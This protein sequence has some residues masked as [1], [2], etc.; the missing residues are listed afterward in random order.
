MRHNVVFF[1]SGPV[2]AMSLENLNK[3]Y[4]VELV[5]T[6]KRAPHHKDPA[7]VEVLA[8]NNNLS[9]KFAD[10]KSELE[11]IILT[12]QLDNACGIVIDYGVIISKKVIDYFN[13][14]IVN[15]HFSLLPQWRGADPISFSLLSGQNTTGVCLMTINEGMD[16]GDIIASES[17][18]I[19]PNDTGPS[20]TYRLINLSN[21]LINTKLADYIEETLEPYP[22]QNNIVTYSTKLQKKDGVLDWYKP[23]TVLE[24]EI[25]AYK[26]WPKSRTKFGDIDLTITNAASNKDTRLATGKILITADKKMFV[27]CRVGSLEILELKP[28]GKNIM[29]IA[30]FLNGYAN[31]MTNYST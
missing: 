4:N 20:M 15:S 10:T 3:N 31:R 1:G 7:P 30:A 18:D 6:K 21:Q 28:A 14:G 9:I 12:S 22:Q 23:S 25:R 27:G 26:D 13:K 17:I 2:A 19:S 8:E 5:I 11:D 16:T 24:R 29:N